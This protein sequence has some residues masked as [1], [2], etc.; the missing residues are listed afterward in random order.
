MS[1]DT[2]H[3]DILAYLAKNCLEVPTLETRGHD[4]LDV[5]TVSVWNLKAALEAA[6]EAGQQSAN[7]EARA[8]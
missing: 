7:I 6:F 2:Q 4:S 3:T 8:S 1:L 5:H